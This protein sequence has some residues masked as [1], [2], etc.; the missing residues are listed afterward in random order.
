MN[1]WLKT[2]SVCAMVDSDDKS[3]T[4]QQESQVKLNEILNF[5]H[6]CWYIGGEEVRSLWNTILETYTKKVHFERT[7]NS[8]TN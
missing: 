4:V 7:R 5:L 1:G 8:E 2:Y 6:V 3:I